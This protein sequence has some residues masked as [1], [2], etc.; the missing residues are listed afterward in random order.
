MLLLRNTRFW[1]DFPGGPVVE[2]LP[3]NALGAGLILGW[4]AKVPH[5]SRPKSKNISNIV[6]NLIKT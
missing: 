1:E 4:E 6:T 2:T 5:A 3:S